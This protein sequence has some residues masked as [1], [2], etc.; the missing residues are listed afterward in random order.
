[1]IV[2]FAEIRLP[3]V[4]RLAERSPH[5]GLLDFDYA[6]LQSNEDPALKLS[7]YTPVS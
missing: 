5:P 2:F 1:M 6:T 4:C 3:R 7:I